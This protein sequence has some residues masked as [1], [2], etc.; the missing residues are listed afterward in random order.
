VQ[1]ARKRAEAG[2]GPTFIEALTYRYHGHNTGE[3][4]TYRTDDEVEQW[5]R[6][7]DP[8]QRLRRALEEERLLPAGQAARIQAEA[9]E[10]VQDAIEFADA[11]PWP[12]TATASDNVFGSDIASVIRS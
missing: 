3:V 2:D 5:R 6:S 10:R 7:R 12:D 9:G 4:T 8:V 11:S 1:A